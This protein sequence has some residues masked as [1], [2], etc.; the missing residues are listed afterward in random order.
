MASEVCKNC[1][2]SKP[3]YSCRLVREGNRLK[4]VADVPFS[5]PPYCPLSIARGRRT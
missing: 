2:Y 4:I 5:L 3:P 1:P